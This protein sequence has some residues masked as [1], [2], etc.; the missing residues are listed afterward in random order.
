MAPSPAADPT[1]R[2]HDGFYLRLGLGGGSLK[3]SGS[4]SPD[5]GISDFSLKGGG[6]MFD[7][8]IG[9]TVGSGFVIAGDYVFLQASKPTVSATISGQSLSATATNDAN[10]GVI[11]PMVEWFPDPRGGFSF[12]GSVG[13]AALTVSDPQ[14]NTTAGE[15][16]FG[17]SLRIG[18]DFWIADQWSLGVAGRFLGGSVSG[19][20]SGGN[21]VTETDS[22]VGGGIVL[23]GLY[24]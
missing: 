17:G 8:S 11:G 3:T 13:V 18:Y 24:H 19:D 15:R 1:A 20:A 4:F 7:L 21:G 14:G 5:I 10:V 23:S 16:G 12:G 9:G 6:V 22:F 2:N